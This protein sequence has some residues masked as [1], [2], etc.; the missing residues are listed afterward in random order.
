VLKEG[1]VVPPA[2]LYEEIEYVTFDGATVYDTGQYGNEKTSIDI[3]FKRAN[4]SA[5]VYL[6][7]VSNSPRL[8][9]HLAQSGY[10]RYG[11][12]AYPTFN[13]KNTNENVATVTPTRTKVGS[14]SRSYTATS[15]TTKFTLPIGGHTPSSGVPT[16]QFVGNIYYFTMSI[17][18]VLVADWIPVRRLS[19]GLECF[20]DKVTQSFIEPL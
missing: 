7:G 6:Y 2:P 20:W 17:D 5:N 19:D 14:Y 1:G 18:G 8:S 10:W 16:P 3:K 9:A 13:T 15:F 12:S 4:T 11:E